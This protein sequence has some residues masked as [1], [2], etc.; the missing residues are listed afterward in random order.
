MKNIF[1]QS[2]EEKNRIRGLHLTESEDKRLSSVLGEQTQGKSE[3]YY[4]PGDKTWEYIVFEGNYWYTRRQ[5]TD[6]WISLGK[7]GDRKY[8][9]A[10][11]KLDKMFPDARPDQE[12]C[13]QEKDDRPDVVFVRREVT[14]GKCVCQETRDPGDLVSYKTYKECISSC[15]GVG[16][17]IDD[18]DGGDDWYIDLDIPG[19]LGDDCDRIK[20]CLKYSASL[21]INMVNKGRWL[22]FIECMKGKH[23]DDTTGCEGCPDYVQGGPYISDKPIERP[24]DSP[25]VQ[26]CIKRG[27]TDV[28]Y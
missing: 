5:G 13:P 12:G 19:E 6:K 27:C 3:I 16:E 18:L 7:T 11:C 1:H 4:I 28:V 15:S 10:R 24:I 14:S 2:D 20:A 21:E 8:Q 25:R 23:T 17:I 22:E 9:E 26:E